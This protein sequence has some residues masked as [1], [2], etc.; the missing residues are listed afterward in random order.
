VFC[1]PRHLLP[2]KPQTIG[3]FLDGSVLSKSDPLPNARWTSVD[4]RTHGSLDTDESKVAYWQE[5]VRHFKEKGWIHQL[6]N[7]VWEDPAFD[8]YPRVVRRASVLHRNNV[9]IPNLVTAPRSP[10]LQ[11]VIDIWTPLINCFERRRGFEDFC[12]RNVPFS[13]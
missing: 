7:Y 2:E 4:L 8:D 13:A 1:P 9:E 11:P 6:F 5:W 12:G 3:P 10:L